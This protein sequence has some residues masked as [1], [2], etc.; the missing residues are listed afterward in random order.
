MVL[1]LLAVPCG[2]RTEVLIF[3]LPAE[4]R[5]QLLEDTRSLT[6]GPLPSSS[7]GKYTP[8]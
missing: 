2:W 5:S 8:C 6:H 1:R 7:K 3:F 4:S